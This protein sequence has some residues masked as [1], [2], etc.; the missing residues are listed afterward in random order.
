MIVLPCI[1]QDLVG[2]F[3]VGIVN[4]VCRDIPEWADRGRIDKMVERRAY[5]GVKTVER[6]IEFECVNKREKQMWIE[7][8]QQLLNSIETG[9]SVLW[10]H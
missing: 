9:S 2:G 8:I 7:G 6:V 1:N 5:F 4:G 10:K 3:D